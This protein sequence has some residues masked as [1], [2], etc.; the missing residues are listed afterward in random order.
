MTTTI[1]HPGRAA[2]YTTGCR[3]AACR[4]AIRRYRKLRSLDILAGRARKL[5]AAQTITHAERLMARGWTQ[6]AIAHTA[7]LPLTTVNSLFGVEHVLTPTARA[8]LGIPLAGPPS[9]TPYAPAV[10]TLR[11]LQALAVLGW[12]AAD[13]AR[14]SGVKPSTLQH[15]LRCDSLSVTRSIANAV[16]RSYRTL[17]TRPAPRGAAASRARNRARAL[18]WHGPLAWADIDDPTCQP[19]A[20]ET[21]ATRPRNRRVPDADIAALRAE[22][23]ADE[24]IATALDCSTRTVQ[25]RTRTEV[26]A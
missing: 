14:E 11:R 4:T 10:G 20:D 25:R 5:P 22:G 1:P 19:E 18:G 12:T 16:A 15:L 8:I 3:Q 6:T 7:G 9:N 13:V 26:A 24:Q 2:C 21:A 17:C 23:L